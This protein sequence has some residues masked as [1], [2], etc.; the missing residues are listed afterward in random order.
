MAEGR[1]PVKPVQAFS[2]S[3]LSRRG[4][5]PS[6][7]NFKELPM[8]TSIDLPR[9]LRRLAQ[10]KLTEEAKRIKRWATSNVAAYAEYLKDATERLTKADQLAEE[11]V[12]KWAEAIG[13]L[14]RAGF[15]VTTSEYGLDLT[16]TTTRK[17]LPQVYHAIGKLNPE[18]LCKDIADAEKK[19]VRVSINAVKYPNVSVVYLHKLRDTDKCKIE[20]VSVP[21]RVEHRL[22]CE[23]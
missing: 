2:G 1:I 21:A 18:T 6:V 3:V 17:K 14:K 12:A 19:L 4:L 9:K 13:K 20:S 15:K 10:A 23:K 11:G 5:C 8:T 22:V 16:V 7:F